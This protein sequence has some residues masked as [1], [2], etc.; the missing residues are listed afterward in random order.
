MQGLGIGFR[1]LGFGYRDSLSGVGFS[2]QGSRSIGSEAGSYWRLIDSCITQLK[3]QGPS[4]TCNESKEEEGVSRIS[5]GRIPGSGFRIQDLVRQGS[6]KPVLVLR[7]H[8]FGSR[9]GDS[10]FRVPGFDFGAQGS[11]FGGRVFTSLQFGSCGG[12]GGPY[13]RSQPAPCNPPPLVAL[14][15]DGGLV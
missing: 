6:Q 15:W 5:E 3:A 1:D 4:R 9:T 11:G 7:V 12:R 8:G 2:V 14:L 10:G 13:C